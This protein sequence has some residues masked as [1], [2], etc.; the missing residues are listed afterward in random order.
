MSLRV[1]VETNPGAEKIF[2]PRVYCDHCSKVIS[3]HSH[4]VYCY[5][6]D[7]ASSGGSDMWFVHFQCERGFLLEHEGVIG[8][9][10]LA[11][12]LFY[13]TNVLDVNMEDAEHNAKGLA[14]FAQ[15]F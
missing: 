9:Q 13:L 2:S 10:G 6:P 5:N 4:G 7:D 15:L 8:S 11:V 3:R 1:V 12:L 14:W